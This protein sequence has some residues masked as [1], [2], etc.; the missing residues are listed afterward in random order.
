MEVLTAEDQRSSVLEQVHNEEG[1]PYKVDI[2]DLLVADVEADE[3]TENAFTLPARD[4]DE[5]WQRMQ[6]LQRRTK[7]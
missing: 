6:R 1:M 7:R 2:S 5:V 4:L 3:I